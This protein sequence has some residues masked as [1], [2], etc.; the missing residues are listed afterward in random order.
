LEDGF[1]FI[2]IRIDRCARSVILFLEIGSN[3]K[4]EGDLPV[5]KITVVEVPYGEKLSEALPDGDYAIISHGVHIIRRSSAQLFN[6]NPFPWMVNI[7]RFKD[8]H[9]DDVAAGTNLVDMLTK[10]PVAKVFTTELNDRLRR[11]LNERLAEGQI[12]LVA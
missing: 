2:F 1:A 4:S 11:E 8:G 6:C 9:C 3:L 10:Y 7:Y 5:K 12:E